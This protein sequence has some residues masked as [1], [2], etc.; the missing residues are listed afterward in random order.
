[1]AS[2]RKWCPYSGILLVLSLSALASGSS[3]LAQA[4]SIGGSIG[5]HDKSLSGDNAPPEST[6]S[7][8]K[9]RSHRSVAKPSDEA[10]DN[11]HINKRSCCTKIAGAWQ[12]VFG[13]T[14]AVKADGSA[15][16]SG[17]TATWSCKDGKYVFVWSNGWVDRAS[18][19][20]D[21]SRMDIINNIGFQFSV[22]RY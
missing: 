18:L 16:N 21:G 5:R 3:A 22:T 17:N 15:S 8:K 14:T 2:M 12:W 10:S 4:G 19:S 13:T 1:M 11:T 20:A 9:Q 6:R 7:T